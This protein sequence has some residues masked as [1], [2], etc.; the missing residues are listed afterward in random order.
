MTEY[1]IN[2][3]V[4]S[5]DDFVILSYYDKRNKG[6][7]GA[8]P[9]PLVGLFQ[10]DMN[11]MLGEYLLGHS[12]NSWQTNIDKVCSHWAKRIWNR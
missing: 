10:V 5:D 11:R 6:W 2:F 4:R 9:T 3:T 1:G 8:V 12:E 7:I